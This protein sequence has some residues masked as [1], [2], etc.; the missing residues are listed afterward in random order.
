MGDAST[1]PFHKSE[2][3]F[4]TAV[5][6]ATLMGFPQNRMAI[7]VCHGN[8]LSALGTAPESFHQKTLEAL[9]TVNAGLL[10]LDL[11]TM[12]RDRINELRS[13]SD[14][15]KVGLGLVSPWTSETDSERKLA[16]LARPA[17]EVLGASRVLLTPACGFEPFALAPASTAI[18]AKRKLASLAKAS[19]ILRSEYCT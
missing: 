13:L 8:H 16:A 5:I 10:F 18:V 19:T 6:N 4:A 15:Q 14:Y 2:L 11:R 12:E 9:S 7:H 3:D 1:V 17:I